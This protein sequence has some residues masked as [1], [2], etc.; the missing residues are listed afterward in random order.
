MGVYMQ[1]DYV[2]KL[3]AARLSDE[4][5]DEAA[6]VKKSQKTAKSFIEAVTC[7]GDESGGLEDQQSV[8]QKALRAASDLIPGDNVNL[9][10]I[11]DLNNVDAK[12]LELHRAR[13][14]AAAEVCAQAA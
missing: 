13:S 3:A 6:K 11:L 5:T 2:G 9:Q 10:T 14:V 1:A 8:I 12:S 7:P 4:K